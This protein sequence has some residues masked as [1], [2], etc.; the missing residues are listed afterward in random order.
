M[1]KQWDFLLSY[2]W[3]LVV[4]NDG[5]E[6]YRILVCEFIK[7]GRKKPKKDRFEG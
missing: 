4:G 5:C 7:M 3:A 2:M 1:L 6:N